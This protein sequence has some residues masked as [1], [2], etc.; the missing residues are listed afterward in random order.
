V[1]RIG[2]L[3][4]VVVSIAACGS[5]QGNE[6]DEKDSDAGVVSD[7]SSS[8]ETSTETSTED[9]ES[10]FAKALNVVS[11]SS[12]VTE[13]E[14]EETSEESSERVVI[15]D[16][17][18]RTYGVAGSGEAAKDRGTIT[19]TVTFKG[20]APEMAILNM[21]ADPLCEEL[22]KDDPKRRQ[23]LVLGD[24]QRLAN[25]I[26]Q[27]RSNL[28]DEEHDIPDEVVEFNQGGCQYDPHVFALRVGQTLKILNPD[29]TLHNV[30]AFSKVNTEFNEAMPK[31]RTEL[32][33]V[34]EEAETTPFAIRCD[35]HPWMNAWAAVFDHPYFA[36]T[37]SSGYFKIGNLPPGTYDLEI[38]H[39]R[40]PT[41]V[42]SV[43]VEAGERVNVEAVMEVPPS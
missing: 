14:A 27:V 42:M 40:L 35:V 6:S 26:I 37:G 21:A 3:C 2:L 39:E 11:G 18:G 24:K 20:E 25:V 32:E 36:V 23:V 17:R 4:F 1:A 15:K 9:A 41:Q 28:P 31:F 13:T 22:S 38:W 16:A 19:G 30:H 33:K 12:P 34:F 5:S 29:G 8:T 10:L 43:T 7:S